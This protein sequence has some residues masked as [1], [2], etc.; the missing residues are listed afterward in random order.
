MLLIASCYAIKC[1]Y[2]TIWTHPE[3]VRYGQLGGRDAH[4]D[5]DPGHRH[6]SHEHAEVADHVTNLWMSTT[7]ESRHINHGRKSWGNWGLHPPPPTLLREGGKYFHIHHPK[8]KRWKDG[9]HDML[10]ENPY[11]CDYLTKQDRVLTDW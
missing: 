10:Y 2:K 3:G 1:E 4:P 8:D 7:Y 5:V 11:L 6:K 9:T